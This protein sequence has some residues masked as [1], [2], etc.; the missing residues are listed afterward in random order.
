MNENP[1][2]SSHAHKLSKSFKKIGLNEKEISVFN[3]GT[4]CGDTRENTFVSSLT[5]DVIGSSL[6]ILCWNQAIGNPGL[7]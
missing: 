4:F 2:C 3:S 6:N 1:D 7:K 5:E